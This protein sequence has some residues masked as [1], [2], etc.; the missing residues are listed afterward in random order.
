MTISHFSQRTNISNVSRSLSLQVENGEDPPTYEEAIAETPNITR[1]INIFFFKFFL[2][3]LLNR[4]IFFRKYCF[5]IRNR[6]IQ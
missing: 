6:T 4:L 1:G 5:S 3:E 2:K